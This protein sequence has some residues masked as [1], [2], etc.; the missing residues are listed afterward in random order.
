MIAQQQ[1]ILVTGVTGKQGGAVAQHL[2]ERGFK[3][4]GLT[5]N[6]SQS[7]AETCRNLGVELVEGDMDDRQSLDAALR[8]TYGV[9]SVQDP[10]VSGVDGEVRFAENL[11]DASHAAGV[12]HFVQASVA[13]ADH[14]TGIPHFDSKAR[15]EQYLKKTGLPCT[16]F[17]PVFFMENWELPMVRDAVLHGM[18]P[19]PLSPDTRLQQVA[20]DDIG[21][22]AAMAFEN[23][24]AWVD[25]E[26]DLAGDDLSMTETASLFSKAIGKPVEYVQVPWDE[27]EQTVGKEMTIMY[28]WFEDIGYSVDIAHCRETYPNLTTLEQYLHTHGWT[29]EATSVQ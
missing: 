5:R 29:R 12:R 14:D 15:I 11:I 10:W 28:R 17:R 13:S 1:T 3:V 25:R 23:P 4:R 24:E 21:A 16:I 2:I 22:V 9:F 20:V 26:F 7:S 18:L 6:T 8:E 19:Q 27:F